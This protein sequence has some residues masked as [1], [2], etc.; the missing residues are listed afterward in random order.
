MKKKII[1]SFVAVGILIVGLFTFLFLPTDV[2]NAQ[3]MEIAI[4]YVGGGVANR[5]ER[6]FENFRR[7]WA[8]EVFHEN[9]VHEVYVHVN[10]GEVLR[11]DRD[12]D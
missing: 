1:M 4:E 8:V 6:E 5:A 12:F 3:A 7:V 2:N 10:S 11:V 9:L